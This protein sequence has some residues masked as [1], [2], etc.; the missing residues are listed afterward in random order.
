MIRLLE[1]NDLKRVSNIFNI[2]CDY[3]NSLLDN[4]SEYMYISINDEIDG[5]MICLDDG[6]YINIK[7]V[8]G[9][10]Q[11]FLRHLIF[12]A[13]KDVAIND[14]ID[15]LDKF[16]FQFD[17]TKYVRKYESFEPNN[18]EIFDYYEQEEDFR[19]TLLEQINE[20]LWKGAKHLYENVQSNSEHGKLF[21]MYGKHQRAVQFC[22][23][24]P[25]E[26]KSYK[27]F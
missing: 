23:S 19:K 3:L 11:Q 12:N 6:T 20:P 5:F 17:G 7:K 13:N 26:N 2:D 9:N 4:V 10:Y 14:S 16:G 8:Q 25:L 1:K 24:A 15:G 27:R 18:I 21:I 22:Q